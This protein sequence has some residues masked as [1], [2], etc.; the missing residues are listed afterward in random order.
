MMKI[1]NLCLL[2]DILIFFEGDFQQTLPVQ[3]WQMLQNAKKKFFYNALC[4]KASGGED[5][6]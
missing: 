3:S 2:L 6:E 5:G 4:I 1:S